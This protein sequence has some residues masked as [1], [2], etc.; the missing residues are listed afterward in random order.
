MVA[1]RNICPRGDLDVPLIG[2]TVEAGA[3][4]DVDAAHAARLLEQVDNW[5]LVNPADAQLLAPP[6]EAP[7]PAAA[8]VTPAAAAVTPP[9][10]AVPPEPAEAAPVPTSDPAAPADTEGIPA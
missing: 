3:S 6:V 10:P 2:A 9:T 4:V 8:P 5:E 7:A 1:I